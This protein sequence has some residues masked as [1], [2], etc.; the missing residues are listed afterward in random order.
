MKPL[1]QPIRH[2]HQNSFEMNIR[3]KYLNNMKIASWAQR[4]SLEM[5]T[6]R[7]IFPYVV[8]F[9]HVAAATAFPKFLKFWSPPH[10]LVLSLIVWILEP[11][12]H[13]L[14]LDVF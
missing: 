12:G 14:I 7:F 2:G 13:A 5:H 11:F 8:S 6:F 9:L 3:I 10:D 1:S 4:T